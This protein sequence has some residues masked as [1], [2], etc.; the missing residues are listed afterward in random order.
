MMLLFGREMLIVVAMMRWCCLADD[1]V[2]GGG[3]LSAK[4]CNYGGQELKTKW[5]HCG[6]EKIVK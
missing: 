5:C 3:I 1:V 2:I 6:P 4:G